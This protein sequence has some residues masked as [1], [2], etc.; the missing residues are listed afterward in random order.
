MENV[1]IS[2]ITGQ[3]GV[4]LSDLL[5]SKKKYYI[6]GISRKM[7]SQ[8]FKSKLLKISDVDTKNLTI[9]NTDIYSKKEV[10]SLIKSTNPMYVFNLTG[11]SSVYESIYY[12][13]NKKLIISSFENLTDALIKNEN[14]CNFFQ[15]SSSEMFKPSK[16]KLTETSRMEPRFPYSEAKYENH[17]SVLKLNKE[18]NWNI[19]SGIMFNHES[20]LRNENYLIMKIITTAIL[21]KYK[22][23]KKLVVGSLDYIRDW[24][25]AGDVACAMYLINKYGKDSS[26]IIGSGNGTKVGNIINYVFGYLGLDWEKYVEVDKSLLRKND[27]EIIVSDPS[28]LFDEFNWKPKFN[29]EQILEKC[30]KFKIIELGN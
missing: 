7:N 30:I 10:N 27:A 18:Y 1:I 22:K 20:E 2:G 23:S 11:P 4:F 28:K 15:A 21:I 17:R 5:L 29:I 19:Y 13:E 14:F 25:Y 26:Y 8:E 3:D 6:F 12:P 24:S 9:V 16:K